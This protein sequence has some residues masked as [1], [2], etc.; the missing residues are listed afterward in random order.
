MRATRRAVEHVPACVLTQG[1]VLG[2]LA[3]RLL[4]DP[5]TQLAPLLASILVS[6]LGLGLVLMRRR[7]AGEILGILFV[8][9]GA[10]AVVPLPTPA[11]LAIVLVAP[12]TLVYL[13]CDRRP[14]TGGQP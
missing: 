8:V 2:L 1:Y 3:A 5:E 11:R 9:A 13:A 14:E 6:C 10:V 12:A 7:Q 4:G